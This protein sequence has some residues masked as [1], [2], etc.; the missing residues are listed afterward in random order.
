MTE[1][2]AGLLIG[3]LVAYSVASTGRRYAEASNFLEGFDLGRQWDR[4][5]IRPATTVPDAFKKAFTK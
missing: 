4:L 5:L 3:T 2:V 1:F